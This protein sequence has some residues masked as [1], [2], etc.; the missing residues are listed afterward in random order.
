[1][2]Q[3][4]GEAVGPALRVEREADQGDWEHAEDGQGT[5]RSKEASVLSV[6]H[7]VASVSLRTDYS[8]STGGAEDGAKEARTNQ[9]AGDQCCGLKEEPGT[10]GV[11]STGDQTRRSL[12][13]QGFAKSSP[14]ADFHRT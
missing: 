13:M 4:G 14:Q 7:N 3:V 1:M 8:N 11:R 10:K 12:Q 6:F 9:V 5:G 2:S